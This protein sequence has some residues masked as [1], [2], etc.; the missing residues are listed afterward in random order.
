MMAPT[1]RAAQSPMSD[2]DDRALDKVADYFKALSEPSRLKLLNALREG[3]HNVTELTAT[4][5]S[6]QANVSRHLALLLGLGV[7]ERSTR[8]TSAF[9][10][11]ADPRIYGLCDLVCGQIGRRIAA[12]E[13]TQR[14]FLQ[15]GGRRGRATRNQP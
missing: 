5:G 2:L 8:G 15:R 1:A 9:Y 13:K 14:E 3:E 7:V 6:S 11:I 4:L 12:E 10:R